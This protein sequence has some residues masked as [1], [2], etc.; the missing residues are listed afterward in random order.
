MKKLFILLF[1]AFSLTSFAQSDKLIRSITYELGKVEGTIPQIN[2]LIKKGEKVQAREMVDDALKQI[3]QIEQ[4]QKEA[5][6]YGDF[7]EEEDMLISQTQ[8]T[9]R[10][11]VNKANQLK[12]AIS[13]YISCDAKLFTQEYASF[14]NEIQGQLADLGCS[15]VENPEQADWVINI[16]SSAREGNKMTTG[17]FTTYFSYVDLQLS[18]D[19]VANGKRVYQNTFTEK[20]GNNISFERAA[21]EAYQE[22][23]PQISAVMKEYISK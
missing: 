5:A 10:F 1:A 17:N 22:L 7:E 18:I 6:L 12:N 15:Y 2:M 11:L 23:S 8:E 4:K 14:K 21:Q 19:K 9:K 16:S 3:E 13:I 20:G